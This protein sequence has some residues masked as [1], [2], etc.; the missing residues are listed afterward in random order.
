[1]TRKWV[2][3]ASPLIALAKISQVGLLPQLCSTLVIP[4]GVVLAVAL[5]LV[6]EQV[7]PG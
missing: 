5:R 7:L 1:M 3:N 4:G 2:I 6:G